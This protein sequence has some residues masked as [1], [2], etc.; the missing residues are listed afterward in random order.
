MSGFVF[1]G[2]G[3]PG[4]LGVVL[5]VARREERLEVKAALVEWLMSEGLEVRGR[6]RP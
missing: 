2:R 6:G 4:V 5:V 3:R 1:E